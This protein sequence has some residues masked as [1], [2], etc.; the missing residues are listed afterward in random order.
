MCFEAAKD[1]FEQ[2]LRYQPNY[3]DAWCN[4]GLALQML[5]C[6]EE[7]L[8]SY[9][10][11]LQQAPRHAASYCNRGSVLRKLLRY[12][13][14]LRSYDV[15]L[16]ISPTLAD[17]HLFRANTLRALLRTEEAIASY[18]RALE[19]GADAVQVHYALAALGAESA[20]A[21][22]PAE[23]VK[24]LFDRYAENF[25]HHLLDVLRYRTPELLLAALGSHM[26]PRIDSI[27]G[28][29]D[30]VDLGCG[31]GLCGPLLRHF[32][33]TMVGVDLSPRMLEKARQRGVYDRL[34]CADIVQFLQSQADCYSLAVA[35][36]VLVYIGDL[37]PLFQA[38]RGALRNGGVCAFSVEEHRGAE[39]VL[40]ASHR[41]AHSADYLKK[42]AAQ[43]DFVIE[44]LERQVPRYDEGVAITGF[45]VVMACC[46]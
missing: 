29:C 32:S 3:P 28:V 9:E 6:F 46:K 45:L 31:T 23:Y 38:L 33:R 10:R 44:K 19:C 20:P 25:D 14:A 15:A 43:F 40:R 37:I 24:N 35:A 7:A 34:E 39:F 11:A 26:A 21:A 16:E 22:S 13:E 27:S 41:Y 8:T 12:E 4:R 1:G 18:R 5:E 30:T 17:A 2:A 42:I 36:D